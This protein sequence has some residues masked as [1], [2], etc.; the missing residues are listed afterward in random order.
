MDNRL[1]YINLFDYY[2]DLLTEKQQHYFEDYYFNNLS[3]SEISENENVSRNAVN[4]QLHNVIEK[5][6]YYEGVLSLYQRA[7]EIQKILKSVDKK[8]K[9]QIEELL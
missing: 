8:I 2:G 6:D 5:L 7:Q 1:Y 9:E 3:L 4:K